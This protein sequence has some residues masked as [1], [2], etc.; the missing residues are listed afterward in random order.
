M[1]AGQ[2]ALRKFYEVKFRNSLTNPVKRQAL[3]ISAHQLAIEQFRGKIKNPV[4]RV[5]QQ[6]NNNC[7]EYELHFFME[8]DAHVSLREKLLI[9]ITS[10]NL[11]GS[12]LVKIILL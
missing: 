8:C 2:P 6:C 12:Y 9:S 11:F 4:D 1:K 3:R 10:I 7:A 5:C